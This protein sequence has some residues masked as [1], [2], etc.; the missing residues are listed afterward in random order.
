MPWTI[1]PGRACMAAFLSGVLSL[2]RANEAGKRS[3]M[4]VTLTATFRAMTLVFLAALGGCATLPENT[5]RIE[6]RAFADTQDTRLGRIARDLFPAQGDQSGFILLGRGLDA[7]LA[8][9]VLAQ[10]AER[11]IDAQYYLLHDDLTGRLFI[12]QLLRAADRGVRVRLLVDDMDLEGRDVA[13]VT[14]DAHPNIEVRIFNPFSRSAGRGA[15]Y[16]SRFGTVTRRMHNK[17]FTVDNQAA[18]L[19]GRNIG[20]EYFE[21]DPELAFGDLDVLGIGPV[22][23][24]VSASF[25]E[26]WNH[27]LAYP[28]TTLAKETPDEAQIAMARQAH[29]A[30][31]AQQAESPYLEALRNSRLAEQLQRRQVALH[32]GGASVVSDHPEKLVAERENKQYRLATGLE[33]YIAGLGRELIV[34]SPYFVPGEEGVAFFKALRARGVRVRIL[35]NSLASTDVSVVHAGYAR[36]RKELL[37]AGV[38]LY[39]MNRQIGKEARKESTMTGGSSKAS[40]HAKSFVLDRQH[41]FIGSMNL[42]PRSLVENTEIGVVVSAPEIAEGMAE[43][44]D[45]NVERLAFRVTLETNKNGSEQLRWHGQEAGVPQVFD[46]EPYTGFWQRF[47]VGFMQLLPIES[48]L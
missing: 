27:A 23:R 48:Q 26:Y 6:S 37:R 46:V 36:Y 39:E 16:I 45:V 1:V 29:D 20:D 8:R 24:D 33:P 10:L 35:T 11:S 47:G 38:E 41:V 4:R 9:A 13:A 30:F 18:V 31:V 12:D 25:D 17:S 44:F 5:D 7:F 22:A 43:W 19:G 14:L 34:Y 40:L 3:R 28:A 32:R 2:R 42:D 15:Q 21:A